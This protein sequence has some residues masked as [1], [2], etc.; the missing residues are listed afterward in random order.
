MLNKETRLLLWVVIASD[1]KIG[2][3]THTYALTESSARMQLAAWMAL[4]SSL[5]RDRIEVKCWPGGFR[6]AHST[7]W[8]GSIPA[9][10]VLRHI[11]ESEAGHAE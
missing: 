11:E 5:G 10:Q 3:L 4:Q 8:S 6:P 7:Y 9:S 1:G 2:E